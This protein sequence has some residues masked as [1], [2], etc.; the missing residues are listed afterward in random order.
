MAPLHKPTQHEAVPNPETTKTLGI[1]VPPTLLALADALLQWAP[2]PK[3]THT[4]PNDDETV[5]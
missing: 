4:G 2:K 5:Q 3:L 1:T